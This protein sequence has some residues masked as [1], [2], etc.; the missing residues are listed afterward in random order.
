MQDSIFFWVNG[1][2]IGLGLVVLLVLCVAGR[3]FA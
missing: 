1:L 2:A 3:M